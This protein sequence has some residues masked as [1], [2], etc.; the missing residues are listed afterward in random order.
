M[1]FCCGKDNCTCQRLEGF[2]L[3]GSPSEKSKRWLAF[4]STNTFFPWQ[5][6]SWWRSNNLMLPDG[7]SSE[8]KKKKMNREIPSFSNAGWVIFPLH[9]SLLAWCSELAFSFT[10]GR[11]L[12]GAEADTRR[13][14]R[15][16][17]RCYEPNTWIE[18]Y[19]IPSPC[20]GMRRMP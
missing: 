1:I 4:L 16:K 7:L 6:K 18:G 10:L 9:I 2:E 8:D 15:W 12:Q 3:F 11:R 17:H 5:D 20:R 13:D 14:Q 19:R